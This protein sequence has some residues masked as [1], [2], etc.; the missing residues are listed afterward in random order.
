[1]FFPCDDPFHRSASKINH[2]WWRIEKADCVQSRTI[3]NLV[4]REGEQIQASL[5]NK[6][7]QI[8]EDHGLTPDGVIRDQEKAFGLRKK[9]EILLEREKV[10][11]AIEELNRGKEKEKHITMS[12]LHET[13]EDPGAIKAT[14]SVDDVCCKKQK[15]EGR[16]KGSLPK[17][18]RE[19]V[20]TTVA[21][22]QKK[23]AKTYTLNTPTISQMMPIMLAFLLS[24]GQ[25]TQTRIFGIFHRW[26]T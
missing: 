19:M 23:E 12:E 6:S 21:H 15:A 20:N 24:N 8:L 22:I 14:I 10:S 18:K 26:S 4:E 1:L 7:K 9:G 16:K 25:M 13:F 5:G 3:A 11:Q 17:E 2:L